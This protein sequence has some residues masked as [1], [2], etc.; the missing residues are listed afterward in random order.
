MKHITFRFLGEIGFV[1][2]EICTFS[3]CFSFSE[4]YSLLLA[5]RIKFN[6]IRQML[7]LEPILRLVATPAERAADE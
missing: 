1:A 5:Y 4:K 6:E 3:A 2:G 7:H